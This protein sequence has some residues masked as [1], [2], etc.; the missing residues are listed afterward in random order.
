MGLTR[1]VELSAAEYLA[2][3]DGVITTAQA[4]T[5]GMSPGQ[6]RSRQLRG[7]WIPHARSTFL[8]AEHRMTEMARVRIA[9]AAHAGSVAVKDI[10]VTDLPL[11]V[12]ASA[13]ELDDGIAMMD[14]AL[15]IKRVTLKE[16]RAALDR[17][18]GAAGMGRARKLLTSAEDLS[19][20]ELER[21]FVRFLRRLG[22]PPPARPLGERQRDHER[23]GLDRLAPS[24]VHLETLGVPAR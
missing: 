16:L 11:T 12:L 18:V 24:A 4:R 7:L 5:P 13:A 22:L 17:N 2:E 6:V 9:G 19:E 15:Q 1:S 20:S 23:T 8:S 10:A 21:K 14:G 3:H